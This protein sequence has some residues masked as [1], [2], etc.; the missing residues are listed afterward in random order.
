MLSNYKGI[1]KRKLNCY[2][3]IKYYDDLMRYWQWLIYYQI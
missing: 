3:D 1:K 2:E